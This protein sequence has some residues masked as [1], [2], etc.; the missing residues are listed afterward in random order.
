MVTVTDASR[1]RLPR[2]DYATTSRPSTGLLAAAAGLLLAAFCWAATAGPGLAD[3][4]SWERYTDLGRKALQAK[5]YSDAQA[6]FEAALLEAEQISPWDMRVGRSL[7]D[8]AATHY[9]Q[10]QHPK[11]I[12]VL[13][14]SLRV[15]QVGFGPTHPDVAQV[16]RNLAAVEYLEQD[17]ASAEAHL[18]QA[19]EIWRSNFGEDHAVIATTL[20]NLAGVYEAQSRHAEAAETLQLA[21][22]IGERVVGPNHESL[23]ETRR[24]LADLRR[25]HG[26]L[27]P[28]APA[29]A[30]ALFAE[31][32][33]PTRPFSRKSR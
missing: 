20:K 27:P 17:Y 9:A 10:G 3:A 26:L 14:R 4:G 21:L 13:N 25:I 6:M 8:L 5:N 2:R 22:T 28:P 33:T 19:L 18:L 1:R 31:P 30:P 15:M 16:L 12:E 29:T 23:T 11:V 7:N 32:S 24:Q